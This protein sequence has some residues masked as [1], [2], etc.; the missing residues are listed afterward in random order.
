MT[1]TLSYRVIDSSDSIELRE[2]APHIVAELSV[3]AAG[4]RQAAEKGFRPLANYIFGNNLPR[5]KIAMTTPVTASAEGE[6]ERIAMTAPVTSTGVADGR[7]R[8]RFSMPA[9][10]TMQTLPKPAN[11]DVHLV[12]VEAQLV[13]AATFRGR[14]DHKRVAAGA[15]RLLDRATEL[16][17][18]IVGQPTWAGYSAPYVPVPLRKWEM[19]VT[20]SPDDIPTTG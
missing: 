7:Y 13:L 6:G 3:E 11:P 8:V 2:Y 10:Y 15:Q 5:E 1:E 20:V 18:K 12:E 4:V 14:D 9:E 19:L 16:D 17:M